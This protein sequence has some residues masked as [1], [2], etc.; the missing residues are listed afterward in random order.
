MDDLLAINEGYQGGACCLGGPWVGES[1]VILHTSPE[2]SS[3][4]NMTKPERA[5]RM[6][7]DA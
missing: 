1:E 2:R 4:T 3:M 7:E 6:R 5:P